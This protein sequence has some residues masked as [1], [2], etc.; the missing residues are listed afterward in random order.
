VDNAVAL[1]DVAKADVIIAAGGSNGMNELIVRPEVKSYAE[2]HGKTVVVDAPDTAYALILYKM[3]ALNGLSKTDYSVFAAGGCTQRR[4]AMG[5][6]QTRVAAMM[7]APCNV[8]AKKDGYPS[9]GLATDVIGPYQADG[10][11]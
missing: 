3:L 5:A 2:I 9:L 7:N 4:S 8:I 11:W 6:A 10:V 1:V